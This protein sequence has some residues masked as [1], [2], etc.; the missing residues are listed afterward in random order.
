[1]KRWRHARPVRNS[2]TMETPSTLRGTI[3]QIYGAGVAATATPALVEFPDS[4]ATVERLAAAIRAGEQAQLEAARPRYIP[5]LETPDAPTL[6]RE[7][8]E[9]RSNLERLYLATLRAASNVARYR[10]AALCH[11]LDGIEV[12]RHV[13][14]TQ[15]QIRSD[16]FRVL[17]A[18]KHLELRD[19]KRA[20]AS[21]D[22]VLEFAREV[23]QALAE[24]KAELGREPK[25]AQQHLI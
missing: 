24:A 15:S 20:L 21:A 2:K 13:L 3:A 10:V 11:P 9:L 5:R 6:D 23:F 4:F 18:L 17:D 25:D 22:R 14:S 12:Q 7:R 16:F 8:Q 19:S 1:M